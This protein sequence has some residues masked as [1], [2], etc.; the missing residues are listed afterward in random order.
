MYIYMYIYIFIHTHTFVCKYMYIICR[1]PCSM[2]LR[3][4]CPSTLGSRLP[5]LSCLYICVYR[6][7]YTGI[8][9]DS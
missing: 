9:I 6:L 2:L 1:N 7:D 8:G 4:T 3:F 5:N